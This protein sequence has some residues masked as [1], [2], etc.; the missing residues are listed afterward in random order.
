MLGSII[1]SKDKVFYDLFEKAAVRICEGANTLY[2][3]LVAI[4][5]KSP[6]N[7]TEEAKKIKDIEHACDTITHETIET[8]NRTFVTPI[9]REDIHLLITKMDDIMDLM[10]SAASRIALYKI[11]T[12]TP[13]A[14]SF[15][16]ILKKGCEILKHSINSMRHIK[17][18]REIISHCV[19]I[20]TLENEGDQLLHKAMV[21]LFEKEK[22]NPIYVIKWKEIYENLEVATDRCEDVANIIEGIVLKYA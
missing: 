22:D 10:D 13:E 21:N 15:A 2:N 19:Q 14:V 3:F 17:N 16:E 11:E 8:L 7:I 20:H 5:N 6:V 18:Y 1:G 12:I 4:G 9:D